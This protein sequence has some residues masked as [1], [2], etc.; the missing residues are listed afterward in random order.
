MGAA[1]RGQESGVK[2]PL[3]L[4]ASV[5]GATVVVVL[6]RRRSHRRRG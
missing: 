4:V 5:A 6:W 2:P 1:E 3:K